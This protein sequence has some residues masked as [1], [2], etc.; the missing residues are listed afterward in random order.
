MERYICTG[1]TVEQVVQFLTS[2]E[3]GYSI[4]LIAQFGW[5]E[6]GEKVLTLNSIK[7][8]LQLLFQ[9]GDVSHVFHWRWISAVVRL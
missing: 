7:G 3:S 8:I 9:E 4:S 5:K 1:D 2:V 6:M